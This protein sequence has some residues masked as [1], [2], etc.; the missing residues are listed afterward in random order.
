MLTFSW[1]S[2]KR[3]VESA[4][5][6]NAYRASRT[7]SHC[8]ST[9]P[10]SWLSFQLRHSLSSLAL[11][12]VPFLT[13]DPLKRLTELSK[14]HVFCPSHDLPAVG[15]LT[16]DHGAPAVVDE[17]YAEAD[18]GQLRGDGD[19]VPIA[20]AIPHFVSVASWPG[21]GEGEQVGAEK[22]RQVSV[23]RMMM[24]TP[25]RMASITELTPQLE[26]KHITA[27]SSHQHSTGGC[28][29]YGNWRLRTS[30]VAGTSKQHSGH[31]DGHRARKAA[32]SPPV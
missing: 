3:S 19:L 24:G 17:P 31:S 12:I 22:S 26:I 15:D 16:A 27:Y 1:D 2:L 28:G 11:D 23:I 5:P 6:W 18:R 30:E 29:K 7:P 9:R 13:L 25:A 14:Q 10:P 20:A 4:K 32:G 21:D 8:L